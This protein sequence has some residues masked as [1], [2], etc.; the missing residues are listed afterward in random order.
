VTI[1]SCVL[2]HAGQIDVLSVASDPNVQAQKW[3]RLHY[4]N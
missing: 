4:Y 1:N 3:L 2:S